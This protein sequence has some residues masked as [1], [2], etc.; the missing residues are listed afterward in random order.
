[1]DAS[2]AQMWA[3][4]LLQSGRPLTTP[5]R[6]AARINPSIALRTDSSGNMSPMA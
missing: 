1:M 3:D 6:K 5:R 4:Y 2:V